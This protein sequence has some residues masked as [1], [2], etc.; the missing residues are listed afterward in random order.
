MHDQSAFKGDGCLAY[1]AA[2][3]CCDS[4]LSPSCDIAI[5]SYVATTGPSPLA[6]AS[7]R[8]PAEAVPRWR[9]SLRKSYC[10]VRHLSV[11]R[12]YIEHRHRF[13]VAT[14]HII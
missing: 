13:V 9:T 6:Q 8:A 4:V 7:L 1:T 3:S 5:T 10:L 14:K 11:D 12:I 2:W